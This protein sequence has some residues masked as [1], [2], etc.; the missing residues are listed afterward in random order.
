MISESLPFLSNDIALRHD[1]IF[2]VEL[3]RIGTKVS[4][5]INLL[6]NRDT[7][8]LL[9]DADEGLVPVGIPLTGVGQ[10]TDPVRL[11]PVCDPHLATIDDKVISS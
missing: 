8:G 7:L 6:G 3:S 9:G 4:N 5:L 1:H 10:E 2:K 11:N